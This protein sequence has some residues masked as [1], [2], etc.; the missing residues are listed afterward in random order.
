MNRIATAIIAFVLGAAISAA[1]SWKV[2]EKYSEAYLLEHG[3]TDQ[4][5]YLNI[6]KLLRENKNAQAI[7]ALELN[8]CIY[9]I[10]D[11]ALRNPAIEEKTSK[12]F[13]EYYPQGGDPCT[14]V[15]DLGSNN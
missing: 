15:P 14:K 10:L 3:I 5:G 13:L 2:F 7:E 8:A 12:Y 9:S 11:A 1:V 6:L 4:K